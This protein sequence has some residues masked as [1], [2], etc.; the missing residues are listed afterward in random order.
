MR[1]L[2]SFDSDRLTAACGED[3]E[4]EAAEIM[5]NRTVKKAALTFL[6][7][8]LP[9]DYDFMLVRI[10]M[11]IAVKWNMLRVTLMR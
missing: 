11:E 10:S 7:H 2:F 6:L 1:K 4:V 8:R 3:N 5:L 9:S